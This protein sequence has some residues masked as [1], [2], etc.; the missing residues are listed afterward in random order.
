VELWGAVDSD[1]QR[2]A[3]RVAIEGIP[4]VRGVTEHLVRTR[5]G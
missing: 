5:A 2:Q 3:I 4:G 1:E